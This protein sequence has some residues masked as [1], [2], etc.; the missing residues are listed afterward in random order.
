MIMTKRHTS[1]K[2]SIGN[3]KKNGWGVIWLRKYVVML[4]FTILKCVI[5]IGFTYF[6]SCKI[7]TE[8]NDGGDGSMHESVSVWESWK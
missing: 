5:F 6:I 8:V 4:C 2:K 1:P 7:A 3:N